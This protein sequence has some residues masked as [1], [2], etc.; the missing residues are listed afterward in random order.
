MAGRS[1]G[2][3][4]IREAGKGRDEN[5]RGGKKP[6]SGNG[7]VYGKTG[8]IWCV[9]CKA[10]RDHNAAKCPSNSCHKCGEH[11]HWINECT[12]TICDWCSSRSHVR[13]TCPLGGANYVMGSRKS[14]KKPAE[15][16]SQQTG[17]KFQ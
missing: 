16:D 2:S 7:K 12:A 10:R 3:K 15:T 8:N 13:A 4:D 5:D 14:N 6:Y 1:G 17:A 11:G 9:I